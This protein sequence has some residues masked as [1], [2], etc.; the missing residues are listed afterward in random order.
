MAVG[1]KGTILIVE[2]ELNNHMNDIIDCSNQVKA[3]LSKIDDK[4]S[5]LKTHY[6]CSAA[7]TLYKQYEEFNENYQIIVDNLLSYKDDLMT[8]KKSYTSTFSDLT[9]KLQSEIGAS[10]SASVLPINIQN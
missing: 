2:E 7:N 3:I 10:A 1:D 5:L 6:A 9:Q 8:L 4:M